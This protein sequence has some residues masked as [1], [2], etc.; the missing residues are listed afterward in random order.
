PQL[1]PKL[2]EVVVV[3]VELLK[4]RVSVL[5]QQGVLVVEGVV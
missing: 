3:G 5:P 2:E 1:I 4:A